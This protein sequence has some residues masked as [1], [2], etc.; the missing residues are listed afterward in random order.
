MLVSGVIVIGKLQILGKESSVHIN[1]PAEVVTKR[2]SSG[3]LGFM[4]YP[5]LPNEL[6]DSV[7]I[8]IPQSFIVGE[9]VP[10][11]S[12]CKFYKHWAA[13]E[14]DKLTEF[15]RLFDSQIDKMGENYAKRSKISKD[16]QRK[17]QS[18]IDTELSDAL[19]QLFEEDSAWGDS[20]VTH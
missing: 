13:E 4:L 9:V 5:W 10:S 17:T 2:S 7:D 6:L 19:I 16:Q 18:P 14:N 20:T 11:K 3:P 8:I 12:L 1:S 15:K